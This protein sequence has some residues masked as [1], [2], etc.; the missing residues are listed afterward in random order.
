[1]MRRARCTSISPGTFTVASSP[2]SRPRNGRP[3]GSV[4]CSA[5]DWPKRPGRPGPGPRPICCC[6]DCARPC[7]PLR[8]HRA[9]GIA[10]AKIAGGVAHGIAGAAEL[11]EL[12]LALCLALAR[13]AQPLLVLVVLAEAAAL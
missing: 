5:R 13:I 10:L 7:A 9:V 2:Y 6:I 3:S 4:S 1:M 12:I 8:F 11:I